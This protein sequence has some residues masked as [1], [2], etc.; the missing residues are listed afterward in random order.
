MSSIVVANEYQSVHTKNWAVPPP[1][2]KPVIEQRAKGPCSMKIRDERSKR[3][4]KQEFA[5]PE[6]MLKAMWQ[7]TDS[8]LAAYRYPDQESFKN[9]EKQTG[10]GMWSNTL[11]QAV[12][13]MNKD[14]FVEDSVALPGCAAFYQTINGQKTYTGAC[15][16]KGYIPEFTIIKTDAAD[17][18]VEFNYGWRTVL[19]RLVKFKALTYSQI[20]KVWGEV[21]FNDARGKHW[22][23]NIKEFRN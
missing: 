15:F 23:Q 7:D 3:W 10:K 1:K 8:K 19:M 22:A 14:L 4:R 18:P 20:N 17:L 13:H 6:E 12:L 9:A 11:I 21:H 5:S 2:P 16:R